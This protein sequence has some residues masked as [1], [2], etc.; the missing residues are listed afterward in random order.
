MDSNSETQ[1]QGMH[2]GELASR[3]GEVGELVGEMREFARVAKEAGVMGDEEGNTK[4]EEWVGEIEKRRTASGESGPG[5]VRTSGRW[6]DRIVDEGMVHLL[7]GDIED[8]LGEYP[9]LVGVDCI[10]EV[11]V[12]M[13]RLALEKESGRAMRASDKERMS[14]VL[15][16]VADK[17]PE[18]VAKVA[19]A[20]GNSIL[21]H[22]DDE[23]PERRDSIGLVVSWLRKC[24]AEKPKAGEPLEG[25]IFDR[26]VG[27]ARKLFD[28]MAG[29]IK[30]DKTKMSYRGQARLD[31]AVIGWTKDEE[32]RRPDLLFV[33]KEVVGKDVKRWFPKGKGGGGERSADWT[34]FA[35]VIG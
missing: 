15:K 14:D 34:T 32:N 31:R 3:A 1:D 28:E 30:N 27:E 10:T 21:E 5:L 6:A 33:F 8:F 9:Q 23:W 17:Q 19:L 11:V 20:V 26:Y 24:F 25:E 29:L 4:F 2:L 22:E 13:I 12:K 16:R 35:P 7:V 18:K